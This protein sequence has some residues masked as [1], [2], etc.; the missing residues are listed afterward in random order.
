MPY[1]KVALP[2]AFS[3]WSDC[4]ARQTYLAQKFSCPQNGKG[5][6]PIYTTCSWPPT[7]AT[8]TVHSNPRHKENGDNTSKAWLS[9]S[10]KPRGLQ[11]ADESAPWIDERN[12]TQIPPSHRLLQLSPASHVRWDTHLFGGARAGYFATECAKVLSTYGSW[13][14]SVNVTFPPPP[15]LS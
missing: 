4:N 3:V 1:R 5:A 6:S 12:I 2:E 10:S 8:T 9:V 13:K 14:Q 15:L 7:A 11:V